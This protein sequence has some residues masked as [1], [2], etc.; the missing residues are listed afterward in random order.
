MALDLSGGVAPVDPRLRALL[1]CPGAGGAP[2]IA[3]LAPWRR[4][5]YTL[6][7]AGAGTLLIVTEGDPAAL[8]ERLGRDPHLEG[9]SWRVSGRAGDWLRSLEATGGRWIVLEE[10][11][12]VDAAALARLAEGEEEIA[13]FGREGPVAAPAARLGRW[14]RSGWAPGGSLPEAPERIDATP[15]PFVR[16]TG[17]RSAREAEEV[18]FRGLARNDSSWFARNVDRALS[19]AISRRLVRF[20]VTPNQITVASML[21]GIAG[22]LV[23]LH[24]SWAAGLAGTLLFLVHTVTDGCDGEIARLKFAESALGAR[25]DLLGDNLVHAFLFPCLAVHAW[26]TAPDGPFLWLGGVSLAGVLVTWAV[27]WIFVVRG[28]ATPRMLRFF[29]AFANREFAYGLFALGVAGR[30]DWF[31]WIMAFGLWFFPV[32]ILLLARLDRR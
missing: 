11:R 2:R 14:L 13:S 32:G 30:L 12:V 9:R 5:L 24:P 20:D 15:S 26:R 1:W 29:E 18:L 3:G 10:S 23:L 21:V 8:R 27:V 16:V 4:A 17:E 6:C 7:R 28:P 22:A 31:V 25:L 19:R